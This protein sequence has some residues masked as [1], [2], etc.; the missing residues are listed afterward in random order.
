MLRTALKDLE[1]LFLFMPFVTAVVTVSRFPSWQPPGTAPWGNS[2]F[3]SGQCMG[4]MGHSVWPPRPESVT[5]GKPWFG[6]EPSLW[7]CL[8]VH[9]TG[10]AG[11][12]KT[13]NL[14]FI[15]SMARSL[16]GLC[17]LHASRPPLQALGGRV[18]KKRKKKLEDVQGLLSNSQNSAVFSCWFSHK[19]STAPG[20]PARS[21]IN[22][23][24]ARLS[25]M[26]S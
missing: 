23:I 4:V 21:R 7:F 6:L 9:S 24:P 26:I 2:A 8:S 19:S 17:A 5:G 1:L 11:R 16:S 25:G 3:S 15:I 14:N 12:A 20:S 13:G 18:R 22:S 10:T